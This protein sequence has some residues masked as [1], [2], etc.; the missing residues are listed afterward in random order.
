MVCVEVPE[1]ACGFIIKQN[2]PERYISGGDGQ[3][4][5]RGTLDWHDSKRSFPRLRGRGVCYMVRVRVSA[6]EDC[7]VERR[8]KPV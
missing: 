3:G 4:R 7:E 1:N 5:A 2:K 6:G 8:I